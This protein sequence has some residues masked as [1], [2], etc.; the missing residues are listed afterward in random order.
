MTD[1]GFRWELVR[2]DVGV[3][4]SPCAPAR[5]LT[6]AVS[7]R[8]VQRIGGAQSPPRQARVIQTRFDDA[9]SR[10]ESAT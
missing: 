5:L 10:T 1:R 6:V 2:Q 9:T 8:E 4:G 3:A 7:A